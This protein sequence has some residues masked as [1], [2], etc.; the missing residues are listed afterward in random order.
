MQRTT[1]KQLRTTS[2]LVVYPIILVSMQ[3]FLISV[4]AEAWM[5]LDAA[6]AWGAAITSVVLAVG[7][8]LFT[9]YLN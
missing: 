2:A 9:R 5:T 1:P 6:V 8:A 4:A 7:C 3:V